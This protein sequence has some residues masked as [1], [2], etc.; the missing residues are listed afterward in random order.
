MF[1]ISRFLNSGETIVRID[2]ATAAAVT[3]FVHRI[4]D[5]LRILRLFVRSAAE[6]GCMA[7]GAVGFVCRG[8]PRDRLRVAAVASSAGRISA[9]IAWIVGRGMT[10]GYGTP[11]RYAVALDTLY[12]RYKMT[13][14]FSGRANSV[15]T[16]AAARGNSAVIEGGGLP[17]IGR[18]ACIALGRRADMGQRLAGCRLA[19]VAVT[20]R[21]QDLRMVNNG[22]S[23]S[24][25][26]V[27][28]FADVGGGNVVVRLALRPRV[29]VTRVASARDRSV[30]EGGR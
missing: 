2:V 20:A 8:C 18:M 10:V 29:V 17:R 13:V 22:G 9:M 14:G 16:S 23:P 24:L 21:P 7:A 5:G 6:V 12:A 25:R 26:D 11:R 15:V 1:T 30:V 28:I 3:Q 19:V 4:V 27:T